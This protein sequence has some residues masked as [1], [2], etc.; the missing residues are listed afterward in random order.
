MNAQDIVETLAARG[1]TLIPDATGL[2]AKPASR[3]TD[4]DREAIRTHKADLLRLLLVD[5]VETTWKP[6]EWLAYREDG[7]LVTAKYA[8]T[9][10]AGAVNVWLNDGAL[11]PV[12]AE[13]VAIDWAP[14]AVEVLEERLCIMLAAGVDEDDARIRAEQCTREYLERLRGLL[15]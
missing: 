10:A 9:T 8:G 15:C 5:R 2:V 1:V 4:A 7:H 14:D 6:G 3:L 13:W 11:R 12:P